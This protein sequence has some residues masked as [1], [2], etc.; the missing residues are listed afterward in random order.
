MS[1]NGDSQ[2]R[3][4][5][6]TDERHDYAHPLHAIGATP[7]TDMNYNNGQQRTTSNGQQR[8]GTTKTTGTRQQQK[9]DGH[10]RRRWHADDGGFHAIFR[11]EIFASKARYVVGRGMR[12]GWRQAKRRIFR[13]IA[14]RDIA[15]SSWEGWQV[16]CFWHGTARHETTIDD[17]H[18][19]RSR[20]DEEG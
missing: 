9:H 6:D 18:E 14:R 11:D 10:G 12:R 19:N 7:M 2:S 1:Y 15:V 3:Y 5:G 8:T 16:V 17:A 13:M 4:G 20:I